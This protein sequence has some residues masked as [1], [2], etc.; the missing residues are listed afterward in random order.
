MGTLGVRLPVGVGVELLENGRDQGILGQGLEN[1]LTIP[2]AHLPAG[3][4]LHQL[5]LLV[6]IASQLAQEFAI[7]LGDQNGKDDILGGTHLDL[8]ALHLLGGQVVDAQANGCHNHIGADGG[9]ACRGIDIVTST[10]M[11]RS[12]GFGG[13]HL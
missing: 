11:V 12:M 6:P 10:Y 2:G 3:H 13:A 4:V 8:V 7:P 5:G 9:E 1:G